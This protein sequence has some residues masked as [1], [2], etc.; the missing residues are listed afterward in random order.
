MI[1]HPV[2]L[3]TTV[4]RDMAL[5][6][7]M[8]G[9]NDRLHTYLVISIGARIDTVLTSKKPCLNPATARSTAVTLYAL[10][11]RGVPAFSE[12]FEKR[13]NHAGIVFE[14]QLGLTVCYGY[15][16]ERLTCRVVTAGESAHGRWRDTRYCRL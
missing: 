2:E 9:K 10:R 1:P 16:P 4:E 13:L 6:M 8:F 14:I 3:V 15:F 5:H 12:S 7:S 11:Q